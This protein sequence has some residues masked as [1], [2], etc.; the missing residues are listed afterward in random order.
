MPKK[1]AIV[2]P[3]FP[4]YRGG[5]G[6]VA[7]TD[8][9][10]LAELGHEVTVFVPGVKPIKK[11]AGGFAV[12]KL[13]AWFR[14]GHAAFVPGVI[15]LLDSHDIVIM[16]FPFFGAV[17]P[18]ALRR[19][20]ADKTGKPRRGKLVFEY[21]MDVAGRGYIVPFFSAPTMAFTP[22]I[23][24]VADRVIVTSFDYAKSSRVAGPLRA[25]PDLFRELPPSVDT[26]RFSPSPQGD[27]R[28][29]GSE[30]RQRWNIPEG[31]P[32]VAFTG[33]LD[34]AHYFKGVP[35]LLRAFATS[36]LADARL[37]IVGDGSERTKFQKLAADLEVSD[38]VIFAGG[39]SDTALVEILRCADIF[40]FPS[41][42]RSEAFGIA[43]LEAMS[44]G[45]PVVASDLPGVRTI[46]RRA[47]TGTP[48]AP[49]SSSSL[50]VALGHICKDAQMRR[51]MGEAARRMAVEEYGYDRR[52][53]RL[54]AIIDELGV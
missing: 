37:I 4:P 2:T 46:V 30:I 43:A 28:R 41:T 42:D 15:K 6:R 1:I 40:A 22:E 10:Q 53:E 8:A 12:H 5:I 18:L 35:V 13:H 32:L 31:K 16:H 23:M 52:K 25:K 54:A 7:E 45:L 50:A 17:E 49:G 19:A 24:S 11:T 9:Q 33:G 51:S 48:V 26:D 38:R 47:E 44:C 20:L 21:H 27:A 39:V 3:V 14:Y 29:C 34:Q 36:E